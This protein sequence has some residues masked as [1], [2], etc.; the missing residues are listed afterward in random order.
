[1]QAA[2][3]IKLGD[4]E[5]TIRELTVAQVKQI[6]AEINTKEYSGHIL[7]ALLDR[8]F[9]ANALFLAIGIKEED[10]DL[11]VPPSVLDGLYDAVIELNPS[12]AAM[13]ERL[14]QAGSKRMEST[15]SPAS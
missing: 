1:M 6:M 15:S 5:V 4:K 11:D 13:M 14:V 7:D 10:F 9:P 12:C 8:A 2:K 3:V